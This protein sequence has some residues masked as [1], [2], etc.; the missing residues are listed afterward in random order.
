[1]IAALERYAV[2]P[3]GFYATKAAAAVAGVVKRLDEF[4]VTM[5]MPGSAI[6][7]AGVPKGDAT[8]CKAATVQQR[9]A[10]GSSQ[11]GCGDDDLI[12]HVG[13]YDTPLFSDDRGD[14]Y[15]QFR[16]WKDRMMSGNRGLSPE[17]MPKYGALNVDFETNWASGASNAPGKRMPVIDGM[18]ETQLR[19]KKFADMTLAQKQTRVKG[20]KAVGE[21]YYGDLHT[22]LKDSVRAQNRT[23]FTCTDH[24]AP[25]SDVLCA[26]H[27]ALGGDFITNPKS[28]EQSTVLFA[29]F[30]ESATQPINKLTSML[31]LEA[32]IY[33]PIDMATDV[34]KIVV[35]PCCIW[36]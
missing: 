25:D 29:V 2:N 13:G 22:V 11:F 5:T 27:D 24:G 21:N 36:T 20:S 18:T 17:E 32:Q 8:E 23:V 30:N 4:P 19:Q 7:E 12:A 31:M 10:S 28:G 15:L 16:I 9:V 26:V 3:F 6:F 1:M 35:A 14:K 34:A 33:G